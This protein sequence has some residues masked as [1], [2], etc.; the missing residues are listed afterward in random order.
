MLNLY[1][2]FHLNLAYSSIE[3]EQRREVVKCCYW[4][5]LRLAR[6]FNLPFGIEASGY[7]L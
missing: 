4:P 6:R 5:L 7:T 2:F 3:E 1:T